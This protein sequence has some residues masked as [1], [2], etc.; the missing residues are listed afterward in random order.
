MSE[1][2]KQVVCFLLTVREKRV[3]GKKKPL[4]ISQMQSMND[5]PANQAEA[6]FAMMVSRN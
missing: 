2:Q 6:S 4:P 3:N 5:G 1:K